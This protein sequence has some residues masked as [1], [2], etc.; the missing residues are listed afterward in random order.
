M[1]YA[2]EVALEECR[3]RGIDVCLG[4]ELTKVHFN[5]VGEKI[6]TFKDVDTGATLEHAFTHGNITSPSKPW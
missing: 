1:P 5:S 3:K 2:N 4:H 6:A